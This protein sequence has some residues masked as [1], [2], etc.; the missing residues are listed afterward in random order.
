MEKVRDISPYGVRLPKEIKDWIKKKAKDNR[1]S[2]NDEII[3]IL[4]K[5][6]VLSNANTQGLDVN[7]H[8]MLNRVFTK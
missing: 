4:E 1:R 6:K 2:I 3:L 8:H 5:E 7:N